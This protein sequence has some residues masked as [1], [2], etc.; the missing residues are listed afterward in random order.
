MKAFLM[1]VL[2]MAVITVAA[3]QILKRTGQSTAQQASGESVRL[4]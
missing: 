3:D 2:A 1:A 4:D